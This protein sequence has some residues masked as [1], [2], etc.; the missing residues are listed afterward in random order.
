[1]TGKGSAQLSYE[2]PLPRRLIKKFVTYRAN[3]YRKGGVKWM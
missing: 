2:K 3:E 1:V